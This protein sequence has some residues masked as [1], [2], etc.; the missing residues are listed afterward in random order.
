MCHYS[1]GEKPS[2]VHIAQCSMVYLVWVCVCIVNIMYVGCG[3]GGMCVWSMCV[4]EDW[5]VRVGGRKKKGGGGEERPM[6]ELYGLY[7]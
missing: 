1:E 4:F 7:V 3:K 6:V 2:G 5:L